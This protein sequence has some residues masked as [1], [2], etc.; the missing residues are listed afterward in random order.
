MRTARNC[1]YM[2]DGNWIRNRLDLDMGQWMNE[3]EKRRTRSDH[4]R[5]ELAFVDWLRT[6]KFGSANTDVV[7]V[8]P[9]TKRFGSVLRPSRSPQSPIRHPLH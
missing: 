1:C 4:A 9:V 5:G 8:R 3:F 6:K 7:P 2:K